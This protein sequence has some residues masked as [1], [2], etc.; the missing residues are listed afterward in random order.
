MPTFRAGSLALTLGPDGSV[1]RLTD[2][3]HQRE[4]L[5][6]GAHPPLLA[7]ALPGREL[8]PTALVDRGNG[9]LEL[10]Y[11]DSG[12]TLHVTVTEKPTHLTFELTEVAGPTPVRV[13]WGPLPT[14]ITE[15][16]GGVVGVVRDRD[17][18]LGIQALNV[19]TVA[20]AD[21]AGEV[22]RLFGLATEHEGG[23]RG[24]RIALF[25]CAEPDA[26]ATIGAI[27]VAEGLPHPML[28]GVWGKVSPTAHLSYLITWDFGANGEAL[29]ELLDTCRRAGLRYLYHGGPFR[30][31][32]H[33]QLDPRQFPRGDESL[34]EYADRAARQGVRVGVHTLTA[35]ITTNDPYVTPVPDPR[36]ARWGTSTLTAAV[37]AA[38]NQIPVADGGAF[39]QR[40]TLSTVILG[41]EL[42]RFGR[43]SDGLPWRLLDCERGAFGTTAAAHDAGADIGMLAD[44]AY[45]TFYPGIDNGMMDEM[46]DRLVELVNRTGVRQISFDGLEGLS[47]YGYPGDYTRNRFVTQCFSRWQ[48]EVISDASNLLHFLWHVHTRMNWG[49]LGQSE[50]LDV[51]N[52]RLNNC[53]FFE[54]NLFPCA[55]GWWRLNL[56]ALDWEA[57]RPEDVEYLLAKAAGF[58]ATHGMETHPSVINAHGY[59]DE[60]LRMVKDWDQAKYEGAFSAEQRTRLREKGRDFHLEAAGER[61]WRLREVRYTPFYWTCSGEGRAQP[62]DP[63]TQLLSFTSHDEGRPGLR[64]PVDNPFAAQPLRFELRVVTSF[65][66]ADPGNLALDTPP[67]AAFA[68][69]SG[70]VDPSPPIA[71]SAGTVHGL[72]GYELRARHDGPGA[73][74]STRVVAPFAQPLD[75]SRHRGLGAWVRGDG[76]GELLFLELT[77]GDAVRQY[78][79][80]VDFTGE[81][82]VEFPL[83][84]ACCL[85]YWHYQPWDYFA[86]WWVALK[87]FDYH[88]VTRL[89]LGFSRLPAGKDVSCAVAGIRALRELGVGVSELA[90]ELAGR[91]LTVA[92]TIPTGHY[93]I[94]LGETAELRDSALRLVRPV[95]LR[96]G[97]VTVPA[98]KSEVAL[99]YRG[100][101]G[102]APWVR[103]E[104]RCEGPDE[105]ARAAETDR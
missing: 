21:R 67:A 96:G 97:H 104:V 85:R 41:Q 36:L 60:F 3:L 57:T 20:G 39:G 68:R 77:S 83:G 61:R 38:A 103:M 70:L 50:K 63:G 33:F 66:P 2:T 64:C 53:R 34:K 18:A 93:L 84:E 15:T 26:L 75:L 76:G 43:L 8:G 65:D 62:A 82:W 101:G 99:S 52:Y 91:K 4:C 6:P 35:F 56:G 51:D 25:G 73:S 1:Q 24:S 22:S 10:A 29:D 71:A 74:R 44:H 12:V 5:P 30:T 16:V 42:V 80:P 31:W 78:Y 87:G 19:Q 27:E 49:E 37:D 23:V 72:P 28:D 59:G 47:T 40:G 55:M 95:E 9:K 11:G 105:D 14:V 88:H 92:D 90:L 94:G 81:R 13:I 45:R 79:V 86:A 98:G 17:F 89:A 48:P 69:S 102:P 7:I 32:G 54:D 100:T 46:T 58:N